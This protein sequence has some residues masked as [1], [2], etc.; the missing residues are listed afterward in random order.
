MKTIKNKP[1]I[2]VVAVAVVSGA[3]VAGWEIRRALAEGVPSTDPL[4]VGGMLTDGGAP[5]EGPRDLT[6]RLYATAVGG[7]AVCTTAAPG[8]SVSGGR[9]RIALDVSCATAVHA[10]PDLWME[11]QVGTTTFPGR[12]KVGAVPYALESGRASEAAGALETRLA[13]MEGRLADLETGP[14]RTCPTGMVAAGSFCI[15]KY[16]ASVWSNAACDGTGTQYGETTTDDYP[17]SFPDNGNFTIPLHACSIP[18]V[19]PARMITWFQAQQ[20]CAA[21]GKHL[22]TNEEWQTAVAGTYDPGSWPG[23]SGACGSASATSGRCITCASDPRNTGQA[24]T[25]AGGTNDCISMHGAEDMIGNLLEW[26]AWWG[27]AGRTWQTADGQSTGPWPAAYNGD[28]TWNLNGTVYSNS[29]YVAGLPAAAIRGGP[30]SDGAAA[31]AFAVNL[32][33][34]PSSW[35]SDIGFRCCLGR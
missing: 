1:W 31:G 27:E 14:G 9:F 5:V 3:V 35:G 12:S 25:V 15:D 19:M 4:Y 20:A 18:A 29:A 23:S 6:V 7:S 11:V 26:V 17:S 28:Y 33:I 34:G 8:T 24:G 10:N 2:V 13:A 16:E 32:G 22:C 30:W 21:S